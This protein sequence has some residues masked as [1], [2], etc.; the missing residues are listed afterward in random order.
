MKSNS[1]LAEIAS[2]ALKTRQIMKIYT[3]LKFPSLQGFKRGGSSLLHFVFQA[4]IWKRPCMSC[5]YFPDTRAHTHRY[6]GLLYVNMACMQ[7]RKPLLCKWL[8]NETTFERIDALTKFRFKISPFSKKRS[9][10]KVFYFLC[11]IL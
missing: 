5:F 7:K 10:R 8:M 2:F 11:I 3:G 6:T 1:L 4:F 9:A